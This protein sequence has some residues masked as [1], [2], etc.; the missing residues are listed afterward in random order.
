MDHSKLLIPRFLRK[1][2]NTAHLEQLRCHLTA[3]LD[4]GQIPIEVVDLMQW[5]HD[6]NL[7]FTINTLLTALERRQ[8]LPDT[9]Y[10]QM[11][12][13]WRENK[14]QFVL[15]FLALLVQLGIVKKVRQH[16]NC[17][18]LDIPCLHKI[19]EKNSSFWNGFSLENEIFKIL[20]HFFSNFDQNF[21]G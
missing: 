4:H 13:C 16:V 2:K 7:S 1:S 17:F 20:K 8:H 19:V 12:N 18:D 3:I 15:T 14:N 9:F 11:D 6:S 10:L 5:P 21:K